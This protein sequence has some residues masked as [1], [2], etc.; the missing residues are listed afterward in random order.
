MFLVSGSWVRVRRRGYRGVRGLKGIVK[1]EREEEKE[2]RRGENK[3]I[4]NEYS[5]KLMYVGRVF[6]IWSI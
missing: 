2:R 4:F 1:E 6:F 5:Y 3:V